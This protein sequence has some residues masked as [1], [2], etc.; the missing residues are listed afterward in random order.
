MADPVRGTERRH[1][2]RF[3]TRCRAQTVVDSRHM[4]N[5]ALFQRQ[6]HHQQRHRIA[7]ARYGHAKAA[8]GS[9]QIA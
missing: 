3:R 9:G 6:Q 8:P 7:A 4:Q 1:L 5:G 2:F